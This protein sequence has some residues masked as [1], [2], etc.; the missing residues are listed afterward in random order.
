MVEIKPIT[1]SEYQCIV[2]WNNGKDEGY[3]FQWAG[4]KAYRYPVSTGQIKARIQDGARIFIIYFDEKPVG[5]VELDRI[6][7]EN[8]SASVCRFI[9][10]DEAKSKGIGTTALKQF[11]AFA[12]NEIKLDKLTLGVFC[13]NVGAIRCY[14]K[15]GFLVKE[16]N[17]REDA[18][19][20]SYTMELVKN[21][22]ANP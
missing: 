10:C 2:D 18:R 3:L 12:F 4:H 13:Y 11:S 7:T 21:R 16:Y 20:S 15:C 19:W 8:S 22:E 6:D 14:E 5:S 9:L 1:E 17:K